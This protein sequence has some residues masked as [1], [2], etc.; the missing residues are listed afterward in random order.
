MIFNSPMF[1]S[2]LGSW[3]DENENNVAAISSDNEDRDFARYRCI[4]TRRD[5]PYR[6]VYSRTAEC[7]YLKVKCRSLL[8]MSKAGLFRTPAMAYSR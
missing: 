3:L 4:L 7:K 5:E 1:Y 6:M 8:D 2:C